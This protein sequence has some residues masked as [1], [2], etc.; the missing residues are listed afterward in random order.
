[1]VELAAERGLATR[2]GLEDSRELPGGVAAANN[3]AM[4][5]AAARILAGK[6]A[7]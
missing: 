7:A 1:M 2:I 3:A 5:A 6:A 4:V